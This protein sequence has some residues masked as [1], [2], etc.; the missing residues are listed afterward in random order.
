MSVTRRVFLIVLDSVG[1][2]EAAD[3]KAFGDCGAHTLRSVFETGKL[4]IP[5]LLKLGIGNIEGL[6]FLGGSAKPAASFARM[7]EASAGKDTTIGHWE[8]AGH[9]SDAPLPTFPDGFPP[10]V[11]DELC[12]IFGTEILCNKPYSGTD[13][14]RDYGEEHLR[15]GKPIVYTSADSVLQIAAHTDVIPLSELY[16]YCQNVRDFMKGAQLGVGRIIA[17]PFE[18]KAGSFHRTADRRDFSVTPP[19]GLIADALLANGYDTIAVGKISD[20]FAGRGFSKSIYTHSN[21]EGMSV[22][23]QLARHSFR[24][25]CFVNLVD[26]DM[27][28]GHRRDAEGYAEALC[29]FDAWLGGFL[30]R[31]LPDDLLII[32][33]DHGCDPCFLASTDHTREDVPCIIYNAMMS[34]RDLGVRYT[35]SDV[36]ATVADFLGVHF[37]C[38]GTSMISE[39]L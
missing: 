35:F 1:I 26:F 37:E 19:E 3:A 30:D 17:R 10:E 6:D 16:G 14:L 24:G 25:L 2:G 21:T 23:S 8:I 33:A 20:I 4:H 36:A 9:I 18:G 22:T 13:V 38:K 28:Y 39:I 11:T 29:E 27:M 7:R 31:L 12:R 5:N 32:T 34:P 15:S